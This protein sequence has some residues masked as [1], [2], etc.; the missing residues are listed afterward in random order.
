MLKLNLP[1]ETIIKATGL[2]H[3]EIAEI[4]EIKKPAH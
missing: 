3:S 1:M 2:S 4:A